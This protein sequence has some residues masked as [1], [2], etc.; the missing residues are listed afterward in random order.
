MSFAVY[1]E[2]S[3]NYRVSNYPVRS[4]CALL[5]LLVMLFVATPVWPDFDE[6]YSLTVGGS[7]TEFDTKLRINSRD[8]SIDNE[9]DIEDELGYDS[10]VRLGWINGKWRI[11]DR[12]RLSVLYIPIIRTAEL[13]TANDFDVGGN[14]IKAGALIGS[15][16]KTH[17]FDIEYIYSFFKRPDIEI[18]FT[19]GIYWMNSLAEVTAAGEI[20]FEGEDMPEFRSGYQA[21][22]RL[23]A[24]LPLIGFTAGYEFNPQWSVYATARYLDVTIS[25]IDGRILNLNLSTEYYFTKHVGAG[26]ALVLFDV[27]VRYNGV[28]FYNTLTYEYSGLQAYLAFKY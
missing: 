17:V 22:Q 25:D 28:V 23:I 19:A 1:L 5:V 8:G 21:N 2:L 14:I 4:G 27:S 15:S 18:G 24:P 3:N 12:H 7:L 20:V 16:V 6:R 26:A 13:T 11:A 10:E 9:I